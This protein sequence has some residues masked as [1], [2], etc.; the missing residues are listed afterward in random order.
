MECKQTG[1]AQ[2][3]DLNIC[4][5]W[6]I[7]TFYY[8]IVWGKEQHNVNSIGWCSTCKTIYL[9]YYTRN[10]RHNLITKEINFQ[11]KMHLQQYADGYFV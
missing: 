8:N 11:Y 4:N 3:V 5:G 7:R 9:Q 6:T 1:Y 2:G 10:N